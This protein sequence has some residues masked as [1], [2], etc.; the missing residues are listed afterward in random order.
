MITGHLTPDSRLRS[1]FKEGKI[2]LSRPEKFR[3]LLGQSTDLQ[4]VYF[5]SLAGCNDQER[6]LMADLMSLLG[7]GSKA[8]VLAHFESAAEI[9]IR[10]VNVAS[11]SMPLR[12][13]M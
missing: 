13:F 9:P 11:V 6:D 7:Q 10:A 2:P 1:I 3:V 5:L 12:A 4:E 8:E